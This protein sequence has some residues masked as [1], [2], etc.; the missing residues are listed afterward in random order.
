MVNDTGGSDHW[1]GEQRH[2]SEPVGPFQ[3]GFG[4]EG[5]R[6]RVKVTSSSGLDQ[7]VPLGW[8]GGG[9]GGGCGG[10]VPWG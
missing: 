1:C 3:P 10:G 8:R 9:G 7:K 4:A 5:H 6:A 2:P